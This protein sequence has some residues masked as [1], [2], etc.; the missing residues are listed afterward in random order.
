MIGNFEV[1]I[2][3]PASSCYVSPLECGIMRRTGIVGETKYDN[4]V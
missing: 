1:E 3:V 2:I 4:V